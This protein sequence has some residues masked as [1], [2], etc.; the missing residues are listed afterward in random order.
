MKKIKLKINRYIF[1]DINE[2]DVIMDNGACIQMLT[3]TVFRGYTSE[4]VKM[5]KKLFNEFKR[6]DFIFADKELTKKHY[7][8]A[9]CVMLY[10]FNIDKMYKI[11]EYRGSDE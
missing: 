1:D 3:R 11:K 10:R 9:D 6:Y 2:N 4:C 5:S 8:H 7:S